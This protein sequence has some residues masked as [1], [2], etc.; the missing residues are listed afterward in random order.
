MRKSPIS[1]S[2]CTMPINEAMDI[3]DTMDMAKRPK[4]LAF[5]K[6]FTEEQ[7]ATNGWAS[8]RY[9]IDVLRGRFPMGEMAIKKNL[10]GMGGESDNWT[11]YKNQFALMDIPGTNRWKS[12]HKEDVD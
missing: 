4:L 5:L 7:I 8:Y 9:A 1:I 11:H 3:L 2:L 12:W 10:G 6:S